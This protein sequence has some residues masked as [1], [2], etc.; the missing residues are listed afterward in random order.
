[1]LLARRPP[2]FHRRTLRESGGGE[3]AGDAEGQPRAMD[4]GEGAEGEDIKWADGG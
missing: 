1:M 3:E 4:G 2:A